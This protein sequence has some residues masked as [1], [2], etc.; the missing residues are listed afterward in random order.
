MSTPTPEA[1]KTYDVPDPAPQPKYFL[2]TL[3]ATAVGVGVALALLFMVRLPHLA[4]VA[5]HMTD[6]YDESSL[7]YIAER[8]ADEMI[9]RYS[10]EE[11]TPYV[12]AME[13]PILRGKF[14]QTLAL[15]K[16]SKQIDAILTN[17]RSHWSVEGRLK[18]VVPSLKALGKGEAARAIVAAHEDEKATWRDSSSRQEALRAVLHTEFEPR[19]YI[20]RVLTIE[21]PI[22]RGRFHAA[23]ATTKDPKQVD[24]VLAFAQ[25]IVPADPGSSRGPD[26]D[27]LVKSL[28]EFGTAA[29]PKLEAALLQ[30]DSRSLVSLAAEALRTSDLP[31]LIKRTKDRLDEYDA[32]VPQ[33]ARAA[34]IVRMINDGEETDATPEQIAAA[35]EIVA[36]ATS[37]GYMIFEMLRALDA[38]TGEQV[39]FCVVRGLSTF[40][41]A[42]AEWSALRIKARLSPEQLVDTLFS[43]IAQKQEFDVSEVET[44]ENLMRELG[45]GGAT[46]VAWNLERLVTEAKGDPDEV[47]WIYKKMGCTLLGELGGPDAIPTLK[48]YLADTGGYV[49]TSTET[50]NGQRKRKETNIRYADLAKK[51]IGDIEVRATGVPAE[52]PTTTEEGE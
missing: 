41:R 14:H 49:L 17:L 32:S 43:Y 5:T 33:L 23:L 34:S 36:A 24:A 8:C 11:L 44:Y 21:D 12:L 9:E 2:R 48:K 6:R 13:D 51:A 1:L 25:T 50:V 3:F 20:D 35:R 37:K 38:L 39:D 42:I 40:D 10:P 18:E 52:P 27:P 15:T 45:A 26:W 16:D 28:G 29:T 19:D 30:T 22:R 4:Y 7:N 31:F 47:F 46:R